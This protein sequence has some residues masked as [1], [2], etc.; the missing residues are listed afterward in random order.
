MG[1]ET[2]AV[3]TANPIPRR[4]TPPLVGGRVQL[5]KVPIAQISPPGPLLRPPS[6]LRAPHTEMGKETPAVVTVNPTPCRVSLPFVGECSVAEISD[7]LDF[8]AGTFLSTS[9]RSS[10]T[11]H[12]NGDR[13][14]S[15]GRN[16][17][18]STSSE[19]PFYLEVRPVAE[20]FNRLGSHTGTPTSNFV[21]PSSTLLGY[22]GRNGSD[23]DESDSMSSGY[24]LSR[25][26][27]P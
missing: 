22:G 20:G 4:V 26:V 12:V 6:I 7:R 15:S 25:E 24:L 19:C 2:P 14:T 11:P 13:S 16:A 18:N 1:K 9:L 23:L 8:P 10:G 3:V 5:P 21:G 17:L 27:C